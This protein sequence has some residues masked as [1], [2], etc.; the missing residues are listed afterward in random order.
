LSTREI[1]FAGCGCFVYF[2]FA[3]LELYASSEKFSKH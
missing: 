1:T 2:L 3:M